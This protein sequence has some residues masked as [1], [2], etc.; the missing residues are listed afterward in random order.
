MNRLYSLLSTLVV[1]LIPIFLV[2]SAVRLWATPLYPQIEYNR[3]GFPPDPYGFTTAERLQWSRYLFDYTWN[4]AGISYLADLTFS[5][6]Q[7]VFNERELSHM[8]DV[9]SLAQMMIKVWGAVA[10]LLV[11]LFLWAWRGSWLSRFW[12]S[13][14][15]G[16]WATIGLVILILVAVAIS[17]QTLFTD[18]HRIF[19]TGDTWVFEW[20][21]TLIRLLP[22]TF[23]RDTFIVIGTLTILGSLLC[24]ILG[25]KLAVRSSR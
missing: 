14:A 17:F 3:P 12:H 24:I 5:D 7:P 19:F 20:S 16:G 11:G 15:M 21:D 8:V 13:I 22:L 4:N 9:K 23:W 25:N 18:F 6:G 10:I 1:A 2:T